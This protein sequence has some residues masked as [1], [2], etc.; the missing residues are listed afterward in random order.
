MCNPS[1]L[2]SAIR[3]PQRLCPGVCAPAK[4]LGASP[5][6]AI[7]RTLLLALG[8]PILSDDAVGWELADR[9]APDAA[10]C[11]ADILKESTATLDLVHRFA[12]YERLVILD[13]IQL[14]TAPPGTLHR[15]TLDDFAA[16]IRMSCAH[17]LNFASAFALA[18]RLGCDIPTDIRIYA[19]EVQELLKFAEGCTP[20]VA[21]RLDALAR[22]IA[23]ELFPQPPCH[24]DG[25]DPEAVDAKDVSAALDRLRRDNA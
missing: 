13:A 25:F 12:G 9:L 5:G 24:G 8:N 6:S 18:R 23:H 1:S 2:E 4:P 7:P 14:G 11:G 16:T 17:D 10:R 21:A 19:V 20:P 22:Q 15:F 3:D